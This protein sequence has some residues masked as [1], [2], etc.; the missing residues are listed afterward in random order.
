MLVLGKKNI[1]IGLIALICKK[2]EEGNIFVWSNFM[3][4]HKQIYNKMNYKF[5]SF[6]SI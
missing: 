1:I 3:F 5:E 4:Q 2:K 6:T